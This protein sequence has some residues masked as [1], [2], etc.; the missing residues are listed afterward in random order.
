MVFGDDYKTTRGR[1]GV[2]H[3]GLQRLY[4]QRQECGIQV[5]ETGR[6]QVGI[7]RRELETGIAQVDRGVKRRRGVQ[8]FAPEPGLDCGL[9]FEQVAFDLQQRAVQAG[10]K[11]WYR[12]EM[13]DAHD[14]S[15]HDSGP[16]MLPESRLDDVARPGMSSRRRLR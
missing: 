1:A 3:R 9:V 5:V 15:V 8:P 2:L 4:A 11:M 6:K 16:Y 10:R 14:G 7:D 13:L 12:M